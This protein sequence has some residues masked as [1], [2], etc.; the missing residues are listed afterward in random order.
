MCSHHYDAMRNQNPKRSFRERVKSDPKVRARGL[1]SARRWR[2]TFGGVVTCLYNSAYNRV[3]S[4]KMPLRLVKLYHGKG[5]MP[6]EEWM[7]WALAHKELYRLYVTWRNSGYQRR[8]K[9]SPDRLNSNLG[10]FKDNIE[11]IP[12]Y[13]QQIR[14]ASVRKANNKKA[15][16]D[17]IAQPNT[18]P[19]HRSI[20]KRMKPGEKSA[21]Y[22]LLNITRKNH[23]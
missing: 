5:I 1:E 13:L 10:Y 11:F 4:L 17:L 22:E 16:H 21:I 7:E 14:A 18:A 23:E 20:N 8:L 6:R 19:G 15:T 9:P 3:T 12:V 2:R